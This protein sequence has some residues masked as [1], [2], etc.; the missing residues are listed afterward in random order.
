MIKYY[1]M[2][3]IT[4]RVRD[5]TKVS[6]DDIMNISDLVRSKL[7]QNSGESVAEKL[8]AFKKTTEGMSGQT[9]SC[10]RWRNFF[11]L[12]ASFSTQ[13]IKKNS[14]KLFGSF[15]LDLNTLSITLKERKKRL[16]T[17]AVPKIN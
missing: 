3:A 9:I 6:L 16:K 13:I 10:D 14:K 17:E 7:V 4:K 11:N 12:K 5:A 1:D 2:S 8:Q 15:T